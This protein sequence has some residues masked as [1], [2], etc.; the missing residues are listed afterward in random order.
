MNTGLQES[1]VQ[2]TQAKPAALEVQDLTMHFGPVRAVD[3]VSFTI[4]EGEVLA[5]VGES[6]SGKSTVG[7]CIV[8]LL[9]P[10]SGRITVAGVDVTTMSRRQLRKARAGTSIV[11]QDPAGS[12]DPRMLV[13][14]VI[15]EPLRL[16]TTKYSRRDIDARVAAELERVGLRAQVA[17]RY[18]HE[19]SGGQRQRISLARAL[20]SKPKLLIADEPTSALDVSVQA[21]V[22]NL[23]ADL[24][25]DMGFACLF[26]T[27]NLAAVDYLADEV[28]VMYLGQIVEAGT[29]R[30]V[31]DEPAHPYT[32][33]LLA[34]APVADPEVQRHKVKVILGDD[35]PS[36]M[37]PPSGCRFHTRCPLAFDRC[38]TE[39]PAQLRFPERHV[40]CHLVT[41]DGS[42]P[43]VR[44]AVSAEELGAA[45]VTNEAGPQPETPP[46]DEHDATEEA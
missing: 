45:P 24:Q 41:P 19:L 11:F 6:G 13:G 42:G 25:R 2:T 44:E 33:S 14:D 31:V 36:A 3:G 39:E 37:D 30:K 18:P 46:A 22:L 21:S 29:R 38:V 15:A 26:I 23:F 28:A 32:Q 1:T 5:L 8:R 16:S 17:E 9:N 34:A 35:L 27:H 7:K 20:I 12:I 4:N 10:T 40:A 43:D